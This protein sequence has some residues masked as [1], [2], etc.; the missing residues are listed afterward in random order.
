[1]KKRKINKSVLAVILALI[2]LLLAIVPIP[3][4]I[5]V[6]GSAEKLNEF[7]TVGKQ[8]DTQSGSF[9][10]TTV[11]IKRATPLGALLAH[12]SSAQT[13]VSK[14]E[15]MGSSSDATYLQLQ[16]YYMENSQNTAIEMALKLANKPYDLE[17]KGIYVMDIVKNSS[18][19]NK[20]TIGDTIYAIDGQTFKSSEEFMKY[21]QSKKIGDSVS[22]QFERNNKK[23]TATGKLIELTANKVKKPGIG[24][25]LVDHTSISSD[26]D[27]KIDAGSIG[28]PS[29]GLMFTLETYSILTNQ[30][31]RNGQ[32][33][34]GTGTISSDGTVGRIGGIDKKVIAADQAG[35]KIFFA[36]NDAI[37]AEEKKAYPTIKTNYEEAKAAAKKINTSMKI[38]P[39]KNVR[40]A[41]DYLKK[42]K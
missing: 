40:D 27:V 3:Y 29:A 13:L 30:D 34:A 20:L 36:P 1:M 23:Q 6:P 42:A 14:E 33:I 9:M 21:I 5:E 37:T 41:L 38:V 11:G 15:L 7:V 32:Q 2:V 31:L 19:A 8:K 16:Q 24:I 17:Y 10:L 39:V 26:S 12:F 4:Y 22:I 25:T 28:G 35:A 18:F